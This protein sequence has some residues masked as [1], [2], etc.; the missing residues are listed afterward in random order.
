MVVP[1]IIIDADT[2]LYRIGFLYLGDGPEKY[3]AA[4]KQLMTSTI[5]DTLNAFERIYGNSWTKYNVEIAFSGKGE[6]F[7]NEFDR[8]S[9]YKEQRAKAKKPVYIEEMLTEIIVNYKY[10]GRN[11][12]INPGV[13]VSMWG[14]ADDMVS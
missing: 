2:L 13:T 10:F 8:E 4:I 14:E 6:K 3:I 7:R 12:N 9:I 1:H 11:V 5:S